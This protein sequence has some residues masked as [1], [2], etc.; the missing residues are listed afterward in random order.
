MTFHKSDRAEYVRSGRKLSKETLKT[1]AKYF[2]LI[3]NSC[4]S[5]D[6][7]PCRQLD[8]NCSRRKAWD[9]PRALRAI[10]LQALPFCRQRR[11]DRLRS[12]RHDNERRRHEYGKPW[13]GKGRPYDAHE[14]KGLP[15]RED[16]GFTP[17]HMHGEHARH[18]YEEC[19]GNPRNQAKKYLNLW[20]RTRLCLAIDAS[21]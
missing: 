5:K 1:L 7:V 12:V 14:K 11:S 20:L 17:C 16:K 18:S 19:R 9:A 21:R 6:L 3:Y 10:Q 2:E 4:L 8:K 15:L 13:D